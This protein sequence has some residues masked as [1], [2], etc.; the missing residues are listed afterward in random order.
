[1]YFIYLYFIIL[2]FF[3]NIKYKFNVEIDNRIDK[4]LDIL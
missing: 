1:M 2:L 4:S 3:E